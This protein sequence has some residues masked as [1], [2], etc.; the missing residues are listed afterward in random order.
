MSLRFCQRGL[1]ILSNILKFINLFLFLFFL[2]NC[3]SVSELSSLDV[4]DLEACFVAYDDESE[5]T[6]HLSQFNNLLKQSEDKVNYFYMNVLG[7]VNYQLGNYDVAQERLKR[8][9]Q[10]AGEKNRAKYVAAYA[11]TLMYLSKTEMDKIVP[12]Y[13]EA[14]GKVDY[15]R[16]AVVLYYIENYRLSGQKGYLSSAMEQMKIKIQA[17][18]ETPTTKRFLQ[19]MQIISNMEDVC[20]NDPEQ[21]NC[22]KG[23]NLEDEKIYLFSTAAGFLSMLLK[24]P[25]FNMK[26]EEEAPGA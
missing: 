10:E 26:G 18:D 13:V 12:A 1:L 7:C 24:E 2:T 14:A 25:P 21:V 5:L 8:S 19:H 20:K 22:Q 4:F 16:W 6:K 3:G 9:F 17:E 23:G 11:L 15:G